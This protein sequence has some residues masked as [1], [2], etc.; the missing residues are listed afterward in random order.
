MNARDLAKRRASRRRHDGGA[1]M[2]I[3]AMT[4]AVLASVGIYAMAAASTEVRMSGNERQNTQTHYLAEFGIIGTA[5]LFSSGLADSYVQRLR[6]N[7]K[8]PQEIC[9]SLANVPTTQTTDRV[10]RHLELQD[11]VKFWSS[12]PIDAYAGTAPYAAKVAPGSFGATP[13]KGDFYVELTEPQD[14][15]VKNNSSGMCGK[16]LTATSYGRTQPFYPSVTNADTG[17]FGGMGVE[18]QRAHL[19]LVVAGCGN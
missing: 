11:T 4:I 17:Q 8:E 15:A 7:A 6:P 5:Q 16:M 3:V 12:S 14:M 13:M 1:I 9:V 18:T 10:C 19:S 2:F